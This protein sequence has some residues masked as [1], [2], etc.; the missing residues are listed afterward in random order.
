MLPSSG[1]LKSRKENIVAY[2]E[3]LNNLETAKFNK[4]AETLLLL[5]ANNWQN[6]LFGQ[7]S[8]A[9]EMTALQRGINRWDN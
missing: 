2:W 5:P 4:E 8:T 6:Y 3:I 1:L 9:I 7:M